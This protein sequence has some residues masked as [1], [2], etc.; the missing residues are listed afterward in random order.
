[1]RKLWILG[2]L[3]CCLLQARAQ[4][5]Y[6][7]Y[8]QSD[9]YSPFFLKMNDKVYSSG[10]EGYLILPQL[11]DSTYT[12]SIGKNGT[13]ARESRFTIPV[14]Q[15]DRGFL[16]RE[17][18]NRFQL[19]DLQT[20]R[21]IQPQESG[22]RSGTS[23]I[24]KD[25]PFTRLLALAADD[26]TL[27][28]VYTEPEKPKTETVRA[29]VPKTETETIKD[30]VRTE[31]D[32]AVVPERRDTVTRTIAASQETAQQKAPAPLP[33]DS[34]ALAQVHTPLKDTTQAAAIPQQQENQQKENT[35][36]VTQ[37]AEKKDTAAVPVT[38]DPADA[39]V[40]TES[41]AEDVRRDVYKRSVVKRRSE[42]S[43]TE[44]FGLVFLDSHEQGVDTIRLLIP[45][46]KYAY[47]KPA[48]EEPADTKRFLDVTTESEVPDTVAKVSPQ[49][50]KNACKTVAGNADFLRLRRYMA[51]REKEEDMVSEAKKYFRSKCYTTEQVKHLS[52]LFLTDRG[53]YLFFAAAQTHLADP[54]GFAAL[55]SEIKDAYFIDR[56]KVLLG[57]R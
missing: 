11:L 49:G 42:S 1:M 54:G 13:Q 44:G 10:A 18:E 45:N 6:F 38:Q 41:V 52:A 25:D 22:S 12:F 50:I 56:F 3:L 43:T 47:Q 46:P 16:I 27:L 7:F 53:K 14:N 9:N 39:V 31:E 24:K 2:F 20:L 23:F 19:F 51:A 5:E 30:P 55:Q 33:A 37:A 21:T 32:V 26:T 28:Y 40:A 57:D 29:P 17:M 48:A 35:A 15:K 34:A 36:A 4:K 8:F